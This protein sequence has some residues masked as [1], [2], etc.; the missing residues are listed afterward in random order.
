MCIFYKEL[1][2]LCFF[3]NFARLYYKIKVGQYL[4]TQI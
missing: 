2:I 3:A 1:S 4:N